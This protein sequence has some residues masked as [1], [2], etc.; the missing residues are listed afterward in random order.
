MSM[1]KLNL[2]MN[3]NTLAVNFQNS[4]SHIQT[5]YLPLLVA[6]ETKYLFWIYRPAM[7]NAYQV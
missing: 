6:T 7:R 1:E 2:S 4:F 5:K 3:L